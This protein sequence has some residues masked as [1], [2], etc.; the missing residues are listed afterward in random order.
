[1]TVIDFL[2]SACLWSHFIFKLLIIFTPPLTPPKIHLCSLPA[3]PSVLLH[4]SHPAQFVLLKYSWVWC[5]PLECEQPPMGHI[6][7]RSQLSFNWAQF[8]SCQLPVAPLLE[9]ELHVYLSPPPWWFVWLEFML[10][11]LLWVRMYNCPVVSRKHHFIPLV[12]ST[13]FFGDDP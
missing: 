8:S 6:L 13:L 11:R 9:A 5:H 1:M 2:K 12:L 10:S 4:S 7:S 3:Q